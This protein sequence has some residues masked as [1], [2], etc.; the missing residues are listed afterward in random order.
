VHVPFVDWDLTT[1]VVLTQEWIEGISFVKFEELEKKNY[2][3]TNLMTIVVSLFADQ[4]F[5]TGFVHCDPH[6]GIY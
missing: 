6:P 1:K 4:I 5:R 2:N 3:L